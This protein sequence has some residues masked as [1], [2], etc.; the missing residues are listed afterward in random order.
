MI[1]RPLSLSIITLLYRVKFLFNTHDFLWKIHKTWRHTWNG[2]IF[3]HI[4]QPFVR[5][6][7]DA[8]E[9]QRVSNVDLWYFRC[10][11]PKEAVEH[12]R[13]IPLP[14]WDTRCVHYSDAIRTWHL[15]SPVTRLFV[16]QL[17]KTNN[18][19]T[20]KFRVASPLWGECTH[21]WIPHTKAH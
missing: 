8:I 5:G 2:H 10:W 19:I 6:I 20:S 13:T 15:K 4:Y 14:Q 21:G 3:S 9:A 18:K 1:T 17:K 11:Q 16:Q 12:F 7:W